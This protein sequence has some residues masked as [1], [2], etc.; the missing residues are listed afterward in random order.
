MEMAEGGGGL[1][2]HYVG[3]SLSSWELKAS[4]TKVSN[5]SGW[6][7]PD[8]AAGD[9]LVWSSWISLH[10]EGSEPPKTETH[11]HKWLRE[12]GDGP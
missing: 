2:R 4:K 1:N 7:K 12:S 8:C 11:Q 6:R 10:F 5:I 9:H 3:V